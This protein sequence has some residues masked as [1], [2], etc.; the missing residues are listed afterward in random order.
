MRSRDVLLILLLPGGGFTAAAQ[1]DVPEVAQ[2]KLDEANRHR[3]AGRADD[4]IARYREVI[5]SAPNVI[6]AYIGLGAIYH[7]GEEYEQ[8]LEVFGSGLKRFP[9]DATLLFN[10]AAT[11][12]KLERFD[13]ALTHIDSAIKA[14]GEDVAILALRGNILRR[15]GRQAEAVDSFRKVAALDSKNARAHYNLGN[16]LYELGRKEEALAS[17]GQAIKLDKDFQ[18]AHYNLG[19][20]LFDLARFDEALQAY[21]V[22]LAPVEKD[23]AKGREVPAVH[24]RAYLNLGAIFLKRQSWDRALDAYGKAARLDPSLAAAQYNV[25]FI[26]YRLGR[27]PEAYK[28]YERAVKLDPALPL[29]YLHMGLID[30]GGGRMENAVRWLEEGLGKLSVEDR[31]QALVTLGQAHQALGDLGRAEECYRAALQEDPREVSALVGLGRLLRQQGKLEEA[32]PLLEK[33]GEIVL[34]G[35][36]VALELAALARAAGDSAR[37]RAMYEEA[38]RRDGDRPEMWP[39]RVNLAAAM[40]RSGDVR[41]A[42]LQMEMLMTQVETIRASSPEVVK[43][44]RTA[45]ALLTAIEGNLPIARRELQSVLS[46]DPAFAP[47][48][49]AGAAIDAIEGNMDKAS[50]SFRGI[51]GRSGGSSIDSLVRAN[52]GQALWLAGRYDE[53]RE[54]LLAAAEEF[55]ENAVVR[56]ALG[57]IAL[58]RGDHEGAVRDLGAAV[59]ACKGRRGSAHAKEPSTR[60][61][62]FLSGATPSD[63]PCARARRALAIALVGSAGEKLLEAHGRREAHR[64]ASEAIA[65]GVDGAALAQALFLRGTVELLDGQ[66]ARARADLERSLASGLAESLK[67]TAR[68]NL[69]V[70]LYRM[71]AMAEARRQFEQA[72]AASPKTAPSVLNLAIAYHD[73]KEPE[74]ALALYDEYLALGG[75]RGEDA[76]TWAEGIRRVYR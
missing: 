29:S 49:N 74:K 27:N 35:S 11:E 30:F 52:L 69:G 2:R 66:D 15:L 18:P 6:E 22:A 54:P 36:G 31:K 33:A 47:A 62:L 9:S 7:Q 63:A 42:R 44:L 24:A 55:P 25:G 58:R 4:A 65:L 43:E 14:G 20:V 17:F 73:A 5:A 75:R 3:E 72:R 32:R 67:A 16:V 76:R 48:V 21:E 26:L 12:A 71:G 13:E 41:D 45:Y 28:A 50:S 59:E 19:A 38:L 56:S 51:L 34:D 10:I 68:N 61:E 1:E 64:L 57:E 8:A 23:F 46:G 53:A 37:E 39:V 70:A 60:L 40:V